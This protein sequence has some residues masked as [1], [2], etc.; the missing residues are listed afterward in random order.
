MKHAQAVWLSIIIYRTRE[1]NKV[2]WL[3]YTT[4]R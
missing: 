2:S 1:D 4:D 3:V